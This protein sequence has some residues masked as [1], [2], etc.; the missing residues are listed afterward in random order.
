MSETDKTTKPTPANAGDAGI[1]ANLPRSR[2]GTRS[3]RRGADPQGKASAPPPATAAKPR[4]KARVLAA[5]AERA[6]AAGGTAPRRAS[7]P[8]SKAQPAAAEDR[9]A[10]AEPAGGIEELAWAGVAAAAEA[11]TLGVRLATRALEAAR[12]AVERR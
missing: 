5:R 1:F 11:A 7:A 4:E 2:P 6:R 9:D 3:P 12:G 10:V 8:S